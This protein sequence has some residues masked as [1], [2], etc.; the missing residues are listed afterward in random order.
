MGAAAELLLLSVYLP[1]SGR[2]CLLDTSSPG[3]HSACSKWGQQL[4]EQLFTSRGNTNNQLKH[5]SL[6]DPCCPSKAI[7]LLLL[8]FL[9]DVLSELL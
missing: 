1:Q 8:P 2:P 3:G 4:K 7:Q 9:L 6:L 5:S